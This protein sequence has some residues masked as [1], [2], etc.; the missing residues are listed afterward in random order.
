MLSPET[1][2]SFE[3]LT[4][5]LDSNVATA[6]CLQQDFAAIGIEMTIR[7]LDWNV[8]V[9]ELLAGNYDAARNSWAADFNDPINFLEMWTSDS[10]NNF[11]QLGWTPE[12]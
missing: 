1:P 2:I 9:D 8:F 4:N 10:G 5:D 11:V 6:E 7:T 12:A 3:Y